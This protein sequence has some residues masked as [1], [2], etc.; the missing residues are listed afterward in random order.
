MAVDRYCLRQSA[1]HLFSLRC[2][3]SLTR[4]LS[5]ELICAPPKNNCGN[6]GDTITVRWCGQRRNI[7]SDLKL[8]PLQRK[9]AAA[10]T[11]AARLAARLREEFYF[12][13]CPS[14]QLKQRLYKLSLLL[15]VRSL[16]LLFLLW[17]PLP[18]VRLVGLE[19]RNRRFTFTMAQ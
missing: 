7:V 6:N 13:G 4:S 3:V 2:L 8:C 18:N 19:H 15:A 17:M 16:L 9:A 12:S 1:K 11:P 14:S 5:R 10:T